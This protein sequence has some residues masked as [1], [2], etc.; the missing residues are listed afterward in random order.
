MNA[1]LPFSVVTVIPPCSGDAA[2]LTNHFRHL[3]I[4]SAWTLL[5]GQQE[6]HLTYKKN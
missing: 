1:H 4:V 5:V 3:A 2:F 6:G